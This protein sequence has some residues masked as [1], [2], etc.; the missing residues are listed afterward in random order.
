MAG[1]RLRWRLNR[2]R[3]ETALTLAVP[4]V[5]PRRP[6][7]QGKARP[8]WQL[9]AERLRWRNTGATSDGAG[10]SSTA[11]AAAQ[12]PPPPRFALHPFACTPNRGVASPG[13]GGLGGRTMA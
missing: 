8:L 2:S 7:I 3:G 11:A 12:P 4:L 10:P 13:D 9:S 5:S 1:P 6:L